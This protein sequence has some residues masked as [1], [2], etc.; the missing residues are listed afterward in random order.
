MS[1]IRS[2]QRIQS[3]ALGYIEPHLVSGGFTVDDNTQLKTYP[4][5]IA[6]LNK[7]DFS[8]REGLLAPPWR[9]IRMRQ[10]HQHV[11]MTKATQKGFF[12]MSLRCEKMM[13]WNES[14]WSMVVERSAS[15]YAGWVRASSRTNPKAES[16]SVVH[17]LHLTA[18]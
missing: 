1:R 7:T 13:A 18:P 6:K 15:R 16:R 17:D 12:A 4:T 11:Q 14:A 10:R 5:M 2:L 3:P 9:A 8:Q